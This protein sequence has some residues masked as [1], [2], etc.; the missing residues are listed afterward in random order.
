MKVLKNL[1]GGFAG[2]IALN[3]LHE[4]VKRFYHNAPRVDLIGEEAMTKLANKA[5]IE[6]PEGDK[7]YAATLAADVVSNAI[8]YSLIGIGKK[9]NL[10]VRGATLGLAAGIGALEL[11]KPLGLSDAPVTRT[12]ITKYLTVAWYVF[13]GLVTAATIKAL[14][15]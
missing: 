3:L 10:Y 9:K 6:A 8:Y 1:A 7:L 15:K 11:T 12:N 5:D 4:T 14:R 13:G 2:A